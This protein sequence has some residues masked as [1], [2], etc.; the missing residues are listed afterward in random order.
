MLKTLG[1]EP[2]FKMEGVASFAPDRKSVDAFHAAVK[3]GGSDE[4]APVFA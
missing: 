1:I 4:G 3:M 2:C